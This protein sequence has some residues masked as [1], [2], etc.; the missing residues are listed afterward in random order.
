MEKEFIG[1]SVQAFLKEKGINFHVTRNPDL[2]AAVERFNRTLKSKMFR[3]FTFSNSKRYID[4]LQ[5]LI[6]D[7][8]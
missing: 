7:V 6:K 2:E 1:K 4:L 5:D 3:Y 8:Q